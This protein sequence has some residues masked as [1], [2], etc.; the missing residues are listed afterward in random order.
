MEVVKHETDFHKFKC[1]LGQWIS[2]FNFLSETCDGGYQTYWSL[3]FLRLL[4][5]AII[6]SRNLS[7]NKIIYEVYNDLK[8]LD[9]FKSQM[10]AS[11]NYSFYWDVN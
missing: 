1:S 3:N 7:S 10:S 9:F 6:G 5:G 2:T 11:R 8:I 4:K